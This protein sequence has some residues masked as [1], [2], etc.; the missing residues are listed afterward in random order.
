MERRTK[1]LDDPRQMRALAHPLRLELLGR[2]RIDGPA[3]A[4]TLA[5]AVGEAV[6]LVSYHLRQL[7]AHGFLEE[8]PELARDG[9]ERWWRAAHDVTSWRGKDFLGT[10]ERRAAA[11]ALQREVLRR[12]VATIETYL[13]EQPAWG[14]EWVDAADNSDLVLTLSVDELRAL[15]DELHAV[16]ERYRQEGGKSG[17]DVQRV[18]A[19][20]HLLPRR[21]GP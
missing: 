18:H 12:Y 5:D 14:E 6:A 19:I 7:A 1:W 3:T 15:R 11:D 21:P 17:G 8:A 2:L 9:R 13:A 20:L 4:S 16:L 10:P